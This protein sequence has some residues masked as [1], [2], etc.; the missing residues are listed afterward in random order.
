M[1]H[2]HLPGV[3][4]GKWKCTEP[5]KFPNPGAYYIPDRERDYPM[6]AMLRFTPTGLSPLEGP[7]DGGAVKNQLGLVAPIQRKE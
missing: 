6:S 1:E 3:A 7:W 4:L 2:I 5:T